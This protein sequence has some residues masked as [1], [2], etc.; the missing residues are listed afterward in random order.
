MPSSKNQYNGTDES[1][2]EVIEVVRKLAYKL[3]SGGQEQNSGDS[4]QGSEEEVKNIKNSRFRVC[5]LHKIFRATSSLVYESV[6][7]KLTIGHI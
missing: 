1:C 7:A 5:S 6:L 2:E 3:Q 4:K